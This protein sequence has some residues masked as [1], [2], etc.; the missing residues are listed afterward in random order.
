[1]IHIPS[2][3]NKTLHSIQ[4][5]FLGF[6]VYYQIPLQIL[7]LLMART[8]TATTGGLQSF[9]EKDSFLGI[10]ASPTTILTA[11]VILSLISAIF[12]HIKAMQ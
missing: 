5:L 8:E 11:S 4:H 6:E 10:E 1:M 9:F 2:F 12:K 7:L 3:C